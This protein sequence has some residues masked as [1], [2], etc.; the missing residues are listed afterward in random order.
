MPTHSGQ[1]KRRCTR[2]R[3]GSRIQPEV[4]RLVGDKILE[5]QLSDALDGQQVGPVHPG[6][7]AVVNGL[8]LG[9]GIF[10]SAG[11]THDAGNLVDQ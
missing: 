7:P 1:S 6:D 3:T 11:L 4:E 9:F 2:T 10:V 8:R 5:F